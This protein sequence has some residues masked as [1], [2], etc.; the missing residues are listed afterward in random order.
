MIEVFAV[1]GGCVGW[2]RERWQ[3]DG[4]NAVS[5]DVCLEAAVVGKVVHALLVSLVARRPTPCIASLSSRSAFPKHGRDMSIAD[6]MI[7]RDMLDG[8]HHDLDVACG[9]ESR[10]HVCHPGA[11]D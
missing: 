8:D 11:R 7:G 5:A 4:G 10:V 6:V 3:E 1:E 9:D 2:R